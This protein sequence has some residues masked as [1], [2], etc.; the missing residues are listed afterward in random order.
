MH[1]CGSIP[2]LAA[3]A[4]SRSSEV[5]RC[6]LGGGGP[7]HPR[8]L[9]PAASSAVEAALREQVTKR[10]SAASTPPPRTDAYLRSSTATSTQ[11]LALA[12]GC[13]DASSR[14]CLLAL[15][16]GNLDASSALGARR[17]RRRPPSRVNTVFA[18]VAGGL[19]TSSRGAS[20]HRRRPRRLIARCSSPAATTPPHAMLAVVGL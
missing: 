6:I 11:L 8:R 16:T 1:I 17:R 13:L 20:R 18:L 4:S 9:W 10:A 3:D 12:T 15:V 2:T 19:D 5:A 14:G 7:L